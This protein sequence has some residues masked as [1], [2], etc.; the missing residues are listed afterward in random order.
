MDQPEFPL[1]TAG[2][3]ESQLWD[4]VLSPAAQAQ[5]QQIQAQHVHGQAREQ[6]RTMPS[7]NNQQTMTYTKANEHL[8]RSSVETDGIRGKGAANYTN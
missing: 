1:N 4:N 6:F 7:M 5:A 3:N 2:S 8:H